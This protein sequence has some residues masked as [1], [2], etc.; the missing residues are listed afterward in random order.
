MKY[1]IAVNGQRF[2]I[3]IGDIKE[4]IAQVNVNGIPHEVLIENY[5]EV[6]SGTVS[7]QPA[8]AP[9]APPA[10]PKAPAPTPKTAPAAAAPPKPAAP[11]APAARKVVGKGDIIAPIPGRITSIKVKEGDT[12][13][14]GQTVAT[15]EAMKMENNIVSTA[16]GVVKEIRA[17]KDAEVATGQVIMVIGD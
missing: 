15:M 10:A 7:S 13:S 17:Q 1:Q 3:K 14:V 6:T 4:G 11:A 9:Q 8:P 2:E 12:V 16:S 5:N